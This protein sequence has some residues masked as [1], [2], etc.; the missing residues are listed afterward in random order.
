MDGY[1]GNPGY[2]VWNPAA[3]LPTMRHYDK[4]SAVAES[5]R[6]ARANPGQQFFVMEACGVSLV[7]TP[8]VYRDFTTELPF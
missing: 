7:A 3:R 8:A 6:L 1:T 4:K 2:L 5:E